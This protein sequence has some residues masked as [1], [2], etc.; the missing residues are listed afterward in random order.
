MAKSEV[1]SPETGTTV[2]IRNLLSSFLGAATHDKG[3]TSLTHLQ[4]P[5]FGPHL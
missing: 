2:S 5:T 1:S 4:E 3:Y